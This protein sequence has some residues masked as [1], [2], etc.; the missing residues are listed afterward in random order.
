[1]QK[2]VC[3]DLVHI[4]VSGKP[5]TGTYSTNAESYVS[6]LKIVEGFGEAELISKTLNIIAAISPLHS[7]LSG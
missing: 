2:N 6:F 4:V 7:D 3:R 1:M 5:S